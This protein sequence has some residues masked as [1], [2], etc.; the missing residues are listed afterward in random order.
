[1]TQT[2]PWWWTRNGWVEFYVSTSDR[3]VLIRRHRRVPRLIS[4]QNAE[5][6]VATFKAQIPTLEI[7]SSRDTS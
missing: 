6:M 4:P 1:M 2:F 7:Q 5:Q 3:Y